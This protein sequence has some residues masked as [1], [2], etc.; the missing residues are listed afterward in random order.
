M[1]GGTGCTPRDIT[2]EATK[3]LIEKETPG[4][5][6]VMM[7]ESL[8]VHTSSPTSVNESF[9]LDV[10]PFSLLGEYGI[11]PYSSGGSLYA[12]PSS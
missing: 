11:F 10:E 8:K 1:S 7:Q 4:L 6:Y 5:I 12:W 9:R 2:P 3:E